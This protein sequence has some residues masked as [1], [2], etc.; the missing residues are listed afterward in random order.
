MQVENLTEVQS[1]EYEELLVHQHEF[2]NFYRT[3]VIQHVAMR[4]PFVNDTQA[5]SSPASSHFSPICAK[6]AFTIALKLGVPKP[7][8][9]SQ[10]SI[11]GKPSVPQPYDEPFL[12]SVNVL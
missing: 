9:A 5:Q 7:V 10:P 12:T 3:H 2:M 11:A 4:L 8:T 6:A 1:T